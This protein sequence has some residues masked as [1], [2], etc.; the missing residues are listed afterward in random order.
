MRRRLYEH[1]GRKCHGTLKKS[2]NC[3]CPHADYVWCTRLIALMTGPAVPTPPFDCLHFICICN[4]WDN[5]IGGENRKRTRG[6][7]MP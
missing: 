6:G 3:V 5:A 2:R 4:E 1:V 7:T